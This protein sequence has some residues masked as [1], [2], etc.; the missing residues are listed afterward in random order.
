MNNNEHRTVEQKAALR[1][2]IQKQVDEFLKAGGVIKQQP[3]FESKR[4][5]RSVSGYV[6][7]Y[8]VWLRG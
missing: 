7:Q 3:G 6:S 1:A 8:D 4:P 2:R 5:D